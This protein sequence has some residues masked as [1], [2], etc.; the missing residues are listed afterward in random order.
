MGMLGAGVNAQV[1]H[2][3]T[4]KAITGDHT[5]NRFCHNT[6]WV[7]TIKHLPCRAKLNPS[8][9]ARVPVI[10]LIGA[11]ITGKLLPK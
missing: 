7:G 10:A 6:L 8:G 5:F 3:L 9:M 11:F 4:A 2:L 1:R